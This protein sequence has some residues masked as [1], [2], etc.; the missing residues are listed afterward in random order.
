[1][2]V[3]ARGISFFENKQDGGGDI[4]SPKKTVQQKKSK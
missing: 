1:M 3:L 4:L 2:T